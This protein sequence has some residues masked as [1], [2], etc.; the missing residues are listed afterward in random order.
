MTTS[1]P[2]PVLTPQRQLVL[3]PTDEVRTFGKRFGAQEIG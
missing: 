3:A 2:I 1:N